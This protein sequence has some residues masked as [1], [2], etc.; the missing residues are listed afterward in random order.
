MA[1]VNQ[2]NNTLIQVDLL[3][4]GSAKQSLGNRVV[5]LAQDLCI[6]ACFAF[7]NPVHVYSIIV[8]YTS[9]W[10]A[11][12]ASVVFVAGPFIFVFPWQ[13]EGPKRDKLI[14]YYYK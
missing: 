11:V 2:R 12:N 10:Y 5:K 8:E 7:K 14:A 3:V 6:E 1:T 9:R 4:Q 13:Q